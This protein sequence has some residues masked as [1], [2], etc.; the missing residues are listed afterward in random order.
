MNVFGK[1]SLLAMALTV[2]GSA[3]AIAQECDIDEGKPG[4][5]A[6]AM[7]SI[8]QASNP[9]E[10]PDRKVQSLQRAVKQLTDDAAKLD[11]A[12][13]AGRNFVLGK[14]YVLWMQQPN[15]GYQATR[16]QLGFSTSPEATVD[17][18]AAADSAFD[19]VT[20]LMPHCAAML[21]DWRQQQ[22]W[23]E[24]VNGAIQAINSNQLDSAETLVRRSL[25]LTERNPYGPNLLATIAQ[26]KGDYKT[27][28]EMRRKTIELA[29]GDTTYDELRY[30]SMYNLGALLGREAEETQDAEQK[31]AL[32]REAGTLFEEYV[33]VQP[34][35]P[36]A[37]NARAGV[38]NMMML[39]GDTS[40]V[41]TMY[42]DQIANP[43]KYSDMQLVQA[44][45]VAARAEKASDAAKLF[46]AALSV[47]AF[48]RDALYNLAASYWA[49][50]EFDK[51]FPLLQRLMQLDPSNPG[52]LR[53]VAYGFQGKARA[54][55]DNAQ[56]RVLNDSIVKYVEAAEKLPQEVMVDDFSR[57]ATESILGG[58]VK[59]KATTA[60]T[61]RMTVEFLNQAGEVVGTQEATVGPVNADADGAFNLK[62]EAPNVVAWRYK[63]TS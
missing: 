42:A 44:G 53:L 32:A 30:E 18:I 4:E 22:P 50:N 48:N 40:A 45:V 24:L 19:V 38:A 63:I 1:A 33:K 12:N 20:Q 35:N 6:R 7:L 21:E 43:S 61:F 29:Q 37:V 57:G 3:T 9:D 52:N 26:A 41:T 25:V 47:N 11:R 49:L 2:G 14:A 16:G 28:I 10:R 56:K 62:I 15:I 39:A 51:M 34:N 59:N 17:L 60:K 55:S 58:R 8:T 46:E 54:L 36:Q 23:V 31:K 13:A 5:I 27:A